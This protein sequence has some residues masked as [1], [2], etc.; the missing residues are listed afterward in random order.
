[1][2]YTLEGIAKLVGVSRSTVSR[3]MNEQ[4]YVSDEVR[5]RVWAVVRQVGYQ[6][7]AAARSLVTNRTQVIGLLIPE[8]VSTI[9]TQP[10]FSLLIG[11]ITEACNQHR[12]Q[13]MLSL[14]SHR[15]EQ[16]GHYRRAIRSGYLDGVIVASWH[17]A[18]PLV[19]RLLEDGVSFVSVG[20]PDDPRI[21]YV[22]V[23][24]ADGARMATDHLLRRGHRRVAT[25]TGPLTMAP[26]RDRL[27]GYRQAL[28][29]RGLSVN[30]DLVAGGDFTEEGG[31]SA[32]RRLLPHK[33]TA[34][35]AASD[36]MAFGALQMLKDAGLAVPGD[37]ALVG[38][39][40]LPL[41]SIVEPALTTIRQPIGRLGATAVEV[42]LSLLEASNDDGAS[43]QRVIL[44]TELIVR[45][46]CGSP[47]L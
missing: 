32:M 39:D 37:V 30:E 16:E 47:L 18:D 33:P 29:G 8:A 27:A 44:P 10:Y 4:P 13:L 41:A 19:P 24:N 17:E 23:D 43:V 38:F 9:F 20:H 15:S 28:A 36:T 21:N 22:D 1:M 3:V 5:E 34:V 7:R 45:A 40:D 26:G 14:F 46:S 35:F 25:I 42:L 2:A 31:H 11:G 6:P 12:Y